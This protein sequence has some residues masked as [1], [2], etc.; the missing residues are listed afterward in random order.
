MNVTIIGLGLLGG[1][2]ALGLKESQLFDN[3]NIIG[4]DKNP[5]HAIKAKEL[6]II[7]QIDELDEAIKRSEMVVLATP[8]DIMVK[9]APIVLE[10]LP[11]KALLIDLG[12][13]KGDICEAVRSH[14]KRDQ[15]LALHPIAGTENSGPE[16]A[17]ASLFTNKMMI[18][19]DHELSDKQGLE[20]ILQICEKFQMRVSY[21]NSKE[22]DLHI[23]YVSHLSHISSFAL[24]LTVLEKEQNEKNIFNMAGSGFS[25]TVRL[26]KSSP[27][28]WSPI[29]QQN[30]GNISEA[31]DAYIS[32]LQE[33]KAVIDN[34]NTSKSYE[35][36]EEAN[37]I[38]RVLLGISKTEIKDKKGKKWYQYLKDKFLKPKSA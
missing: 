25:S 30:A 28:M 26:A 16:A 8:V 2:F 36:M 13:T 23:A 17:F 19:C 21:M 24:G 34:Q 18:I 15:F 32:K 20:L 7:D 29:F 11:E 37:D 12:S 4:V 33:F 10:K 1:S 22:H 3:L 6:G 9:Q 27:A 31:L 35:L 14:A 38:R 5:D